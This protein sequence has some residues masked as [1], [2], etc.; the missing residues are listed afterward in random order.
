V[1][2]KP[3]FRDSM[4][5]SCH[6]IIIEESIFEPNWRLGKA[7]TTRIIRTDGKP[8]AIAELWK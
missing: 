2:E 5:E 8:L 1:A 4:C 3:S 7:R 6:Y